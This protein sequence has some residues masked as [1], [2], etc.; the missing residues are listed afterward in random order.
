M[1]EMLKLTEMLEMIRNKDVKKYNYENLEV[2]NL[3]IELVVIIYKI[4]A[5]FPKEEIFGLTS[6]IKR[7]STSIALNIA[8]GS[9]RL[10][11]KDFAIFIERSIGSTIEVR[12]ALEISEKLGFI[13]K[14]DADLLNK[15]DEIFFKLQKLKKYLRS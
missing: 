13:E 11:K 4:T 5:K 12:S 10:S 15:I 14:P 3:A 2:Y 9:S 8:E 7:A 6:Q 1:F